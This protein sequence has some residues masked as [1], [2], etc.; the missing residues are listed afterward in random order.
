[1]VTLQ[2][3]REIGQIENQVPKREKHPKKIEKK[4]E[5]LTLR[6]SPEDNSMPVRSQSLRSGTFPV[7]LKARKLF[8]Q[9]Q[10]GPYSNI[11]GLM[12]FFRRYGVSISKLTVAQ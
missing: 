10:K 7:I 9:R 12:N 11:F 8:V 6:R 1:M 5:N 3:G 2:F 4:R